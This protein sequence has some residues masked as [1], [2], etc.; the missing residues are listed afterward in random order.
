MSVEQMAR[1]QAEMGV[2]PGREWEPFEGLRVPEPELR[3]FLAQQPLAH[4]GDRNRTAARV[5]G[6]G[7]A[8][9]AAGGRAVD[10]GGIRPDPARRSRGA[11]PRSPRAW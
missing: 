3:A 2:A 1:F 8:R 4:S 5:R 7:V 11:T 10:A 6:S 9:H